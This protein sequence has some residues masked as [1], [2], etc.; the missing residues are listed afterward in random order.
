MYEAKYQRYI[1]QNVVRFA[2]DEEVQACCKPLAQN[3]PYAGVPLSYDG[4]TVF[5]DN[6]DNHTM[7]IGPTGCKKSRTTVF[8]TV[9]SI[10]EAGE[11]AVVNDPKGEIYRHTAAKAEEKGAKVYV[12]NFRKPSTSH[13]WNPLS[14]A[15]KFDE[16]GMED[17]SMQC[18]ND[19]VECVI[20][21]AIEKTHD[22]YWEKTS[23]SF[24][25]ALVLILMK[26]ATIKHFNLTNLLPF[27]YEENK[28]FLK[29]LLENMDPTSTAA[30]GLHSVLDLEADK[31]RSC[32][33]STLQSVISVFVENKSLLYMLSDDSFNIEDLGKR[34]TLIYIIYPDEKDNLNFLVN[35]FLTQCYETLVASAAMERFDKLQVRVNFVLDEFSNLTPISKFDNRISEA[36]SKNIRY[37]LFVQSYGQL[38]DKYKECA[39][40]ILSNCNN[41][42]CFSSKEVDFLRKLSEICGKEIDYNGVRQD[43]IPASSMQYFQKKQES[44]EVLIIK[45]GLYPYVTKLP[46]F[47]TISLFKE[48]QMAQIPR[49]KS[50]SKAVFIT[51]STWKEKVLREEFT[52]PYRKVAS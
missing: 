15:Y 46:D 7:V 9:A 20:K 37:F 6:E 23:Q 36:R 1:T 52:F 14:Q 27:C 41:W 17:E 12:L 10:I 42:I 29:T 18:V 11:S 22:N 2:E 26:S 16:C 5:V 43:L 48:Y 45:Q 49:S 31:T 50:F 21:P 47:S 28:S 35:L 3:G 39:D 24:L 40:T 51:F 13:F 25:T 30:F 4:D 38:K 44:V 33:Y 34:Q 8:T 19:F 32:V